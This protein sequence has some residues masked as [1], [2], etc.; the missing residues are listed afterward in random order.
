MYEL[1]QL[2]EIVIFRQLCNS[3]STACS[4]SFNFLYCSQTALRQDC[5]WIVKEQQLTDKAIALLCT[6]DCIKS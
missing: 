3:D 6:V 5:D 2:S 1:C 4:R